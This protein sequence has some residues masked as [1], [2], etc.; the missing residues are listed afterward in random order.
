MRSAHALRGILLHLAGALALLAGPAGAQPAPI[1]LGLS[2]P[3]TGP[4]AVAAERERW[5]VDLAVEEINAAGGVLGR[6]LQI[7]AQDNRCNPS[8]A[9]NVANRLVQARVAAVIGAH[10]STATLATMPIIMEAQIPMVSG[11]ASSPRITELSGIGGNP[12]TFR[13]NPADDVMMQT[14]GRY[15]GRQRLFRTVAVVAE[16][17]DFG[18]GGVS[19]FVPAAEAAGLRILSTDIHPQNTPDFT[20]ILTRLQRARP[21]AVALF[22]L[23]GDQINFLRFAMQTG[24]RIPYTGRAE[25]GGENVQIIRAGGM[26]GSV[27]AWNYSPEVDAPENRSFVQKIE[28]RHRLQPVLQTWSGYDSVRLL[29]QAIRE[30]GT[31]E[32][33]AKLRDAIARIRFT[34]VMG[35]EVTFDERN[36]AGRIVVIQAVR[37]RQVTIADLATTE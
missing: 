26:E 14:L 27:S 33:G 16:D 10:C 18:R 13:I 23:G 2:T 31:A 25:L 36:Q 12:W 30:A 22:Q 9:A 7:L 3:V 29:A 17:S 6:P 8:E 37:N 24:V 20:S 19:A 34:I 15:L 21:D 11:I 28:Q 35:R 32:Q 4:A 5:G 1:V